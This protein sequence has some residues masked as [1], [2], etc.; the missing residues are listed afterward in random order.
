MQAAPRSGARIHRARL[1]VGFILAR[2]FTLCAFA[3]FVDVL[4][5][6]GGR[7][8]PPAVRSFCELGPSSRTAWTRGDVELR[9]GG[10][11]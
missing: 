9:G 8:R 1:R 5:L 6:A 4:R 10:S 2:R 3:N 11:A 7:G